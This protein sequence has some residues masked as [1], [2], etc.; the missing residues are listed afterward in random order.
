MAKKDITFGSSLTPQQQQED[1]LPRKKD[2]I[3]GTQ[4]SRVSGV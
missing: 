3:T 1:I 2:E 4:K